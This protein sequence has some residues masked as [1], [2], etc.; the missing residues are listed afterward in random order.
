MLDTWKDT[1]AIE[2]DLRAQAELRG[3]LEWLDEGVILFDAQDNVRAINSR[4]LQITGLGSGDTA[5]LVTLER[6]IFKLSEH[7][8]EPWNFSQR[9]RNLARGIDGESAKSWNS[10]IRRRELCSGWRG[11]SWM[12]RDGDLDAWKYT[13]T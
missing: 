9:W 12:P 1:G 11:R 6:L 3:I 10:C 8:A 2:E 13:E 7:V 4:F 5:A